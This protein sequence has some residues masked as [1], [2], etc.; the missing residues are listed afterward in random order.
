M[1][2]QFM[3]KVLDIIGKHLADF[4]FNVESLS[5]KIFMSRQHLNRKIKALTDRT[6]TEFIR[7]IRLKNAALIL[8][9]HQSTVTQVAYQTGFSSLSF[10]AKAFQEEFGKTPSAYL[11][12]QKV[13]DQEH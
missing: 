7:S 8:D 5:K 3:E 1:D 6:A 2:K 11:A 12:D 4:E 10:F 9:N 13:D